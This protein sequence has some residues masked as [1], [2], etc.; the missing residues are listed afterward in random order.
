MRLAAVSLCLLVLCSP[1][2]SKSD[3]AQRAAA[4]AAEAPVFVPGELIVGWDAAAAKSRRDDLAA[5]FDLEAL[6]ARGLE[7]LGATR[8][9]VRGLATTAAEVAA[10]LATVPG[11][12]YAEPNAVICPAAAPTDPLYGGVDGVET[13]LQRWTFGG[14]GPNLVLN[15]EAA[16]D[17]TTGDPSVV[18]AVLDSGL[19]LDNPEFR[20]VWVNR[21]EVPGN[22]VDDDHNGYVDDLNGY[23]FHNRASG[24][25]PD[26]G[27]GID[28]DNN[29]RADDSAP[30][31]TIAA[32]ILA[33][34]HDGSG[35]AGGAPGC[36]L[37]VVK[38]FGDD[39]GVTTDELTEAIQYAAD[40]GADV[41]NL[42]LSTVFNSEALLEA[43]RYALERKVVVVAAAGNGDSGAPQYPASYNLVVS[44]GG[45]GSGFSS[46]ATEGLSDL[47]QINGRWPR[48]Q[49]G[50]GAVDVVAPA[51]TLA[52]SV[53]TVAYNAEH[54]ETPV[55]ATFYDIFEGT[56][57]A[58]PYVSA[59][60]GLVVS[61]D[62][63]IHGR[64]TLGPADVLALLERTATDL[65]LDH[66]DHRNS[67]AGWDGMGRVNY[68][69][70]LQ[71]I[72]GASDPAPAIERVT[73]HK[74][75]LRVFGDG[76]SGESQVEVNGTVLVQPATFSFADR[77]LEI[78]GQ[79]R[80]LGIRRK[81][82]NHIVVIERGVRSQEFVY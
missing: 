29:D 22:G 40:N 45:S 30:H 44:V 18:V 26:L 8:F 81:G 67:G 16:W 61:R 58:T 23:D 55:G 77:S 7:R 43:V 19:D 75:V 72:P 10:R 50:F 24:V 25:N 68:L 5:A 54:P 9:R 79:K 41:I 69:A 1:A 82:T 34:A 47:G 78:A 71:G 49:Y 27:D 13:D 64:R 48:S 76:F 2:S 14:I 32:S 17:V 46:N 65:P 42:S 28:N 37:M 62:I 52:A 35:M 36:T 33:A 73:F 31:G 39:G 3:V 20:N 66:S 4:P 63:A 15:A 6:P 21:G 70:A 57:F 53:A 80:Q 38:I 51:V 60:A 11:V 56:S 12:R 74:K 59:L